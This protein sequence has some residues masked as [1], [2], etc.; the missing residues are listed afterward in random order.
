M[1]FEERIR[2]EKQSIGYGVSGHGLDGLKPYID[3]RTIG[4]EHVA[5]W[6]KK[7]SER[8][9]IE[10]L[11]EEGDTGEDTQHVNKPAAETPAVEQDKRT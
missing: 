10:V 7:M 6:R 5:E 4:M 1:T 8:V 2:G 11:H 3:K 9:V